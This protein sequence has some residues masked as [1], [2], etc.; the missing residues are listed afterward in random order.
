MEK[1]NTMFIFLLF[2]ISPFF[3]TIGYTLWIWNSKTETSQKIWAQAVLLS[4]YVAIL[5]ST[6]VL[7]GDFLEYQDYFYNVPKTAFMDFVLSFGKDP[8][9]YAF[10]YVSYYLFLGN[11]NLFVISFT[12]INYILL[13]Y[14]IIQIAQKV[15]ANTKI[16]IMALYFMAFFFQELA[17]SGNLVRQC[18][19]QSLTVVFL[20]CLHINKKNKWWIAL[21]ALCTHISCLPI[22]GIGIIPTIRK[23]SSFK[24]ITKVLIVLL[25]FVCAFYAVGNKLSN[26]P[27]LQ[28]IYERA[29]N[30]E[31]LAGQDSWQINVGLT[32]AMKVLLL[33]LSFMAI[34]IYHSKKR[35]DIDK[36]IS[37]VNLNVILIIFLVISNTIGAY[38]LLMRY[39]FFVYAFQNTLVI[40]Y[41]NKSR[42]MNNE[43]MKVSFIVIMMLYFFYNYTHNI[44]S[45]T[46]IGEA[47]FSPLPMLIF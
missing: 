28:Y 18:L 26:I 20:V 45:Y 8:L 15:N 41:L 47:I 39:F 7:D 13:S 40:I 16:T 6:K 46:S 12:F 3:A 38:Y 36:V 23:R 4:L 43:L 44:F 17:A 2:I 35:Q 31:Q 1:K 32:T 33:L 5:G 30:S 24:N 22:L 27:Y 19:A 11:W 9:Y 37:M 42:L 34:M 25:I 10:T 29:S 21:C 14:A